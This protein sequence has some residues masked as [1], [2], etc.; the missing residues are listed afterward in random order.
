MLA[1]IPRRS[2]LR[3][4]IRL[5]FQQF[6]ENFSAASLRLAVLALTQAATF[7]GLEDVFGAPAAFVA[8]A[9]SQL[10]S[11]RGFGGVGAFATLKR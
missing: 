6:A 9:L 8:L 7:G 3:N 5:D 10:Q 1:I 11:V 2:I 4:V